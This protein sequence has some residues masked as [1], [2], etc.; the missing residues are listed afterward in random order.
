M[1]KISVEIEDEH[2]DAVVLSSLERTQQLLLNILNDPATV[3]IRDGDEE[4]LLL[5]CKRLIG[6][7]SGS[8]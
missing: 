2:L 3:P 7:Y 4:E 5:A 8:Y 6:Y 1:P